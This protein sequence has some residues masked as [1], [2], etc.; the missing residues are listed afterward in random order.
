M[1]GY[2]F[3]TLLQD[4]NGLDTSIAVV[5]SAT[6]A[7]RLVGA[8]NSAPLNNAGIQVCEVSSFCQPACCLLVC[9]VLAKQP[10]SPSVR[11]QLQA[12]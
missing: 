3:N 9:R 2:S 6:T 12:V 5:A 11:R 10:A 7:T 1:N 4:S 8:R